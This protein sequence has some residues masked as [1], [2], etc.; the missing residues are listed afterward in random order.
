MDEILRLNREREA[1]I[2]AHAELRASLQFRQQKT[3]LARLTADFI[4]GITTA[5]WAAT[6]NRFLIENS[7]VLRSTDDFL[8]SAVAIQSHVVEGMYNPARREKR[9]LLEA[10]AKYLVVDQENSDSSFADRLKF[11]ERDV[12]RAPISV[13]DRLVLCMLSKDK[14]RELVVEIRSE[15]ARLCTFVHPSVP[16]LRERVANT[17]RGIYLG[18][19]TVKQFRKMNR[20][21]SRF[22][23]LCLA[24]FFHG[25][26]APETGDA[27][28][29]V[30]DDDPAWKFHRTK[31][32]KCVS[33]S[34]DYKVERKSKPRPGA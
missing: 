31:Y 34:F 21:V 24:L 6:R 19:D 33:A 9:H 3:Y 10:L 25:V 5:W 1:R 12:N 4:R 11:F 27:F 28:I 30:F 2:R 13:A 26:G 17:D 16:Q 7:L 23:D 29:Q 20:D 32:T 15:Y 14:A 8:E 22:F 18:F